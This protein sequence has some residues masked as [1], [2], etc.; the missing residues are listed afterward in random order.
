MIKREDIRIRDPYV[1]V[2]NE[3]YYLLGTTPGSDLTLYMSRDLIDYKRIGCMVDDGVLAG[4]TDIWAPELHSYNGKYYLIVSVYREDLGR[5][6]MI[7][8]S[9]AIDQKFFPL[10]GKYITPAGW[11]CLDA[12]LFIWKGKPYLFFSNEWL[13]APIRGDGDGS[14]FVAELAW[15]LT[16][17]VGDPHFIISGKYCGFSKQVHSA[18]GK[19]HGYVAEGPY[20]IEENGRIALYWSTFTEEGYCIVRSVAEDIF[21]NYVFDRFVY[22]KDGGH[23]MVFTDLTNTK[24]LVFHQPNVSPYE[25][26]QLRLLKPNE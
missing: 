15:D 16:T 25:R 12:S 17:I 11:G 23:C 8:V 7:L 10:T 24:R 19:Y 4:Y 22:L 6:S 21:D 20:A 9:N 3:Q 1:Y 2:E 18:D 13:P 14:L 26:L 5:G